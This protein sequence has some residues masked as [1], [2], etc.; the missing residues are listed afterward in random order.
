MQELY[1][2]NSNW[3]NLPSLT[4][5]SAS[6]KELVKGQELFEEGKYADSYSLFKEIM[7]TQ[8]LA[9]SS[10]LLYLGVS[11]LELGKYDESISCFD[12]LIASEA[13]DS[14]KG[15][16]YKVLVYLKQDNKPEAIK[17]LNQ[18]LLDKNNYNYQKAKEI[19]KKLE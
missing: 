14:S 4:S 5:R 8:D 9:N 10:V 3:E 19:L 16:W 12:T 6:K 11:S 17:V 2:D 1:V 18:I 13:I 7:E 15:Y